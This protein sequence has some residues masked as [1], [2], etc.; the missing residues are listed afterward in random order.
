MARPSRQ[1][2]A[3][4]VAA[5]AI[6]V[7]AALLVRVV[8]ASRSAYE[9]GRALEAAGSL[10][11]AELSYREAITWHY[12]GNPHAARAVERMWALAD[13]AEAEN[14][15]V[16]ARVIVGDLRSALASIRSVYQPQAEALAAC[17]ERLAW[18][19]AVTDERVRG[20]TLSPEAVLPQYQAAVLR[21]HAPAV[22]WSIVLGVG[23]L[24]WMGL[25]LMGIV[26]LVPA[27]EGP[28]AWRSAAPWLVSSCT[29]LGLWLTGAAL[30]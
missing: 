23:F 22:G 19:L 28:L 21:D 27:V 18:L 24:L 26:R 15:P 12:P 11:L 1:R 3:L 17:N 13:A 6:L 25:A 5:A 14:D 20:G 4:L 30:A 8:L 10:E 9:T 16:G 29:A 2:A 7:L